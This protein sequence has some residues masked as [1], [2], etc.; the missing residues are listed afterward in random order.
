MATEQEEKTDV[1]A[2]L[3]QILTK[4]VKI[5]GIAGS[6]RK[7]S[8]NKGILRYLS[9][10]KVEG[11]EFEIVSIGELP[12]FNQDLEN[13]DDETKDPEPVQEFR[14]KIR[15]ADAILFAVPEYNYSIAAPLK[16]AIDW[17]SRSSSGNSLK[18]KC[19]TLV[20]AGGGHGSGRAQYHLRQCAVFL[21][22]KLLTKPE[23]LIP[24]FTE[25][26]FDFSSGDLLSDKWKKRVV[27]QVS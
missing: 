10:E 20:G 1:L 22:L 25:N 14:K 23:C 13:T 3:N 9:G 7:A 19:A 2:S 8:F 18:G 15:A 4:P 24:A 12:L 17:A 21:E 27:D 26:K 16:N 5:I 11:I 6:L